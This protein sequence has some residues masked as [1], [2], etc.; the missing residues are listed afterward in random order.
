MVE[1]ELLQ[2]VGERAHAESNRRESI[3]AFRIEEKPEISPELFT[4]CLNDF[5]MKFHPNER[6]LSFREIAVGAGGPGQV[7][8]LPERNIRERLEMLERHS[9]GALV[10]QESAAMQQVLRQTTC[11]PR[12]LLNRI[13]QPEK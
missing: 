5:W 9:G 8:K 7:F 4:Y 13:Y 3:Y 6:T 10:Y 11:D 1:L 2:E 12:D